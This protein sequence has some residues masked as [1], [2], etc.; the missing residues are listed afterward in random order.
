[1]KGR[2]V[3]MCYFSHLF[4]NGKKII[5]HTATHIMSVWLLIETQQHC[6]I[7]ILKHSV[8]CHNLDL[9]NLAPNMTSLVG[10]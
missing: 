8:R 4:W 10:K 3:K 1:M 5:M 7:I 6:Y 2:A 9:N